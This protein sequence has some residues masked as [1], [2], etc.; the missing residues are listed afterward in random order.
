MID[1][2]WSLLD[3]AGQHAALVLAAVAV[4]AI[5]DAALGVGAVLPGET[6]VVL[7]A[8]ALAD[9]PVH[10]AFAIVAAAAGAF[11]GDHIGFLVGRMLGPRLG[12]TRLIRRL[13]QDEWNKAR[14][15]VAR[16]FWVVIVARLMP[17]IRTFVAAA[18]GASSIRYGRFALICGIAATLWA[19]IWVV[20]GATMGRALLELVDRYTAPSLIGAAVI[21][22]AVVVIRRR[23]ARVTS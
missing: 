19:T 5:V 13:G 21:V 3:Q 14:S 20:G 9:N 6:A 2:I 11:T 15:F 23:R 16:R 10:V 12:E 8:I 18:A 7:A 22:L 1:F 17:G 4:F